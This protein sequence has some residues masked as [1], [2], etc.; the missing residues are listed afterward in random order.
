MDYY[1]RRFKAC[2]SGAMSFTGISSAWS[3][4]PY[5]IGSVYILSMF[6]PSGFTEYTSTL[7]IW[8]VMGAVMVNCG[9]QLTFASIV[10][11]SLTGWRS[12]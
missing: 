6:S 1:V 11:G 8:A 2:P 10:R 4:L 9:L 7:S 5:L 12:V 3:R